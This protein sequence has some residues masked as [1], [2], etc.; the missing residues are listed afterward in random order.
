MAKT[1]KMQKPRSNEE[2]YFEWALIE[3]KRLGYVEDY[4]FEET[5]FKVTDPAYPINIVDVH[6][7]KTVAVRSSKNLVQATLYTVDFTIIWADKAK[8]IFFN[9]LDDKFIIKERLK[10]IPLFAKTN[11]S[12]VEI[13]GDHDSNNMTRAFMLKRA[14]LSH[15]GIYVNLVKIP[16]FFK[17]FYMP[18][19]Y[20]RTDKTLKKRTIN[21]DY[22]LITEF[23]SFME[24]LNREIDDYSQKKLH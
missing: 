12:Y 7:R 1:K 3:L 8:N 23:V 6:K 18:E 20:T 13:K 14:P 17:K 11:T 15:K 22:T 24:Q 10:Y 2:L 5:S 16:S 4:L 9:D 19:R 21:Y